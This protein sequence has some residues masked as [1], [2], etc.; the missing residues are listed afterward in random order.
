VR[1]AIKS[2]PYV[3][4]FVK[5]VS[6]KIELTSRH[7]TKKSK[8]KRQ[9]WHSSFNM[10]F[11]IYKS[12]QKSVFD[13]RHMALQ[14]FTML[15]E[16]LEQNILTLYDRLNPVENKIDQHTASIPTTSTACTPKRSIFS[17][18]FQTSNTEKNSPCPIKLVNCL[19]PVGRQKGSRLCS[20][21]SFKLSNIR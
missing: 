12:Y 5:D 6:I 4:N 1:K 7:R 19:N 11:N 21:I 9:R 14:I 2:S 18:I 3:S 20:V 17:N 15:T 13:S 16:R 8:V 10:L